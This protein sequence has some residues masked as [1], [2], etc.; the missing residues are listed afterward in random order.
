V[1]DHTGKQRGPRAARTT[2]GRAQHGRR[3]FDRARQQPKP[4]RQQSADRPT[5]GGSIADEIGRTARPGKGA[6][7]VTAFERAVGLLERGRDAAA[8]TA[9]AEAKS[10]APRSGAVREVLGIALYRSG[11]YKEALA[12]LQAYRRLTGRLDQNHLIADSFRAVGA[13][14]KAVPVAREAIRARLPD[15]PRA[16]SAIVAASALADLGRTDEALAVLAGFPVRGTARREHEVRMWYVEGDLL[17]RTG[18]RQEAIAT[19]RRI[20]RVEPD[21]FDVAERIAALEAEAG[22]ADGRQPRR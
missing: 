17:E 22:P 9:A 20:L 11:R 7:A 5:R 1:A 19:F 21:A 2:S 3:G 6:A 13:P 4:E 14:E 15:A 12:E 16:E 18:R 8:V 10:L